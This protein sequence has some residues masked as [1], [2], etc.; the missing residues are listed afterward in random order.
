M[1]FAEN[2]EQDRDEYDAG[3][4]ARGSSQ[5]FRAAVFSWAPHE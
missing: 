4:V 1:A 5:N 2:H 3:S